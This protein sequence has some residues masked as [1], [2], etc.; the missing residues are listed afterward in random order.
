MC[1]FCWPLGNSTEVLQSVDKVKNHMQVSRKTLPQNGSQL[2]VSFSSSP[3]SPQRKSQLRA[4][5]THSLCVFKGWGTE[6]NP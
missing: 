5:E 2:P 3:V 4:A 6:V 1:P